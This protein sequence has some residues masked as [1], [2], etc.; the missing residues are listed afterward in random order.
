M[1]R[2]GLRLSRTENM[3]VVV[4]ITGA[5]GGVYA[6]R[7]LERLKCEKDVVVS[8][9]GMEVLQHETGVGKTKLRKLATRYYENSEMNCDIA[10]GRTKFNAV[11]IVPCSVNTLSKVHA[12][13]CD[14]LITRAATVAM[15]EG[16]KLIL[17]PREMPLSPIHIHNMSELAGFGVVIIPASPGFYLRPKSIDELVDFVVDRIIQSVES[18]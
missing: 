11:V 1:I 16:R 7:L 2:P 5:S 13:I 18:D 14:N 4:C 10:S 17:V 9:H 3:R 6:L 15:K 8:E 12:G